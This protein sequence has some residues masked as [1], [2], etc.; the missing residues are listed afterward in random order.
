MRDRAAESLPP[1]VRRGDSVDKKNLYCDRVP[2]CILCSADGISLSDAGK[3]NDY[4]NQKL[5]KTP[6][7]TGSHRLGM[8]RP[9]DSFRTPQAA[10]TR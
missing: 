4:L 3:E 2:Y 7:A 6:L 5:G 8:M 1:E 10:E 9:T